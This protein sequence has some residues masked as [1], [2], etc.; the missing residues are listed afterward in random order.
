[1]SVKIPTPPLCQEDHG[2]LLLGL[3][4]G[5]LGLALLIVATRIYFRLGLR[6]GLHAD[7]YFVVASLIVGI[8]GAA[9]LT[10]LVEFGGGRHIYCLPRGH[11]YPVLKWSLLAQ[12]CN[13]IG[14]GLVKISVCLCVLRLVDRAR[15]RL[16]Q[17]LWVLIA[18]VAAS[19]F[20]QV[21]IFLI[22]CRPLNALWDP[23]VKGTCFS[24]HVVYT[25]GYTNYGLDALTDIVCACIPIFVIQRLQMNKRTKTALCL[26]MG[27]GVF[28][29]GCAIAK[30]IT[31]RALFDKD[32]TWAIIDPAVWTI[33]EHYL[34]ITVA[35][36]PALKPLF[37]KILDATTSHSSGSKRSFQKIDPAGVLLSPQP[38]TASG[39]SSI[40]A[41]DIR[42][43]TEIRYSSALELE[44]GRDYEGALPDFLRESGNSWAHGPDNE[45]ARN[46]SLRTGGYTHK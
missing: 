14:I 13:V 18:F 6:N 26:L 45:L 3:G 35:S 5:L 9:F 33:T 25:A 20:V 44:V 34:G 17:F 32:Y 15:R 24:A 7:D 43:K 38:H 10:K 11:I 27:L 41:N 40:R 2:P 30:C 12:I 8:V 29:A 21:L 31:L 39:R 42:V 19:H 37:S 28:T 23:T 46:S 36:M 4:W 22:Q 1:M 16:S